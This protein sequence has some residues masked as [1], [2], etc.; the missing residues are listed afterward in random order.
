MFFV[1]NGPYAFIKC[2]WVKS[3]SLTNCVVSRSGE[4]YEAYG[5]FLEAI[6]TDV[7]DPKY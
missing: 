7:G 2:N 5:P 4:C 1:A 3:I 6:E